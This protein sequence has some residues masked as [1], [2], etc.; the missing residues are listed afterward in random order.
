MSAEQPY[1]KL[2]LAQLGTSGLGAVIEDDVLDRTGVPEGAAELHFTRVLN[3]A[4]ALEFTLPIDDAF[5]TQDNFAPGARELHLYRDGDLI[6][7][8]RLWR[9]EV[10]GWIS[11]RFGAEGFYSTLAHREVGE[12]LTYNNVD[13]LDIAWDL[14]DYTQT[15]PGGNL[16]ISRESATPAGVDRSI[17]YCLDSRDVISDAIETLAAS[18]DGFDFEVGADKVWRTYHP[19][20]GTTPGITLSTE[21]DGQVIDV[22]GLSIDASEIS[23]E[24]TGIKG[25]GSCET[26]IAEYAIDTDS[27]DAYG[28]MQSNIAEDKVTPTH[29]QA[30]AEDALRIAKDPRRQVQAVLDAAMP[31]NPD[32]STYDLGDQVTLVM[33]RGFA[34]FDREFRIIQIDVVAT[35]NERERVTVTLD[36]VTT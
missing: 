36:G 24:V 18:E 13:E 30:M 11:V 28:L 26:P 6:W 10:T 20:R 32:L 8:G 23:N 12:D 16:G 1:Y 4:G 14:I 7:G 35:P 25:G 3:A 5:V 2:S 29:L 33:S 27:R 9:A 21:I 17:A 22:Q 31:G 15:L 19:L 34:T